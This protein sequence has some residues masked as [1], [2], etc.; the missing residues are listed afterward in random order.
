[1]AGWILARSLPGGASQLG[2]FPASAAGG[3]LDGVP[4]VE[5]VHPCS[6][7]GGCAYQYNGSRVDSQVSPKD[8]IAGSV[9]ITK[10]DNLGASGTAGSRPMDDLPFKPQN[11]AAT[12]IY[13]HSFSAAWINELRGNGTRFEDN[14]LSDGGNTVNYGFPTST[15]RTI[16]SRSSLASRLL[17]HTPANRRIPSRNSRYCLPHTFG[18]HT[19]RAGVRLRFEQDND[20]LYG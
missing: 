1:M 17:I 18:T 20:N 13:I 10:L 7:L 6:L 3:G 8:L 16:R 15:F 9:Y 4:D 2:V 19:I 11:S 5:N 14:A 12:L